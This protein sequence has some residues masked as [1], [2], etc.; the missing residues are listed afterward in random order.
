MHHAAREFAPLKVSG[1]GPGKTGTVVIWSNGA[2]GQVDLGIEDARAAPLGR[3]EH[4]SP[5]AIDVKRLALRALDIL[6]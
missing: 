4:P 5:D 2:A 3:L 6:D 1:D